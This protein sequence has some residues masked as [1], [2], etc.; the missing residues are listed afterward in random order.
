MIS[1][2]LWGQLF[3]DKFGKKLGRFGALKNIMCIPM[4][5]TY[6][7]PTSPID[8]MDLFDIHFTRSQKIN[9]YIESM[10]C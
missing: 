9:L 10:N 1:H 5:V 2:F 7:S 8:Y 3:K 4:L 6:Q